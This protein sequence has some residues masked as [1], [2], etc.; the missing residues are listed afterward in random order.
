MTRKTAEQI[1]A[2]AYQVIGT[3]AHVV[4]LFDDP[5]VAR[6]LDYFSRC[7]TEDE[8]PE[9]LPWGQFITGNNK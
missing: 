8:I 6:A 4:G 3:L 5:E 9:I 2:E 7:G 1:A